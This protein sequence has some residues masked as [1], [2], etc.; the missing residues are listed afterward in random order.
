ML[1]VQFLG[2]AGQAA[3]EAIPLLEELSKDASEEVGTQVATA[4][5]QI[6]ANPPPGRRGRGRRGGR[7]NN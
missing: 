5:E 6:K 2:L 1:A 7:G 3:A 4:I